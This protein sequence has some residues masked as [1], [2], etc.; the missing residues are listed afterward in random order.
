MATDLKLLKVHNIRRHDYT[1]KK[2]D[3]LKSKVQFSKMDFFNRTD[4]IHFEAKYSQLTLKQLTV[5]FLHFINFLAF[6]IQ[7]ERLDGVPAGGDGLYGVTRPPEGLYGE[8]GGE[9]G[10]YDEAG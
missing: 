3:E 4:V 8:T 9:D 10:L 7:A 5:Q 1:Q 2:K 6:V